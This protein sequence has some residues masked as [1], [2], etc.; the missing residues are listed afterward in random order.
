M[1]NIPRET[2]EDLKTAL[3]AELAA[4]QEELAERGVKSENTWDGSSLSEGEEADPNDAADNIE[5]L[6][7]NVPLVQDLKKR[8]RDIKSAL[9]R[10]D[11][12]SYGTCD[13]CG[14][15][16]T[17]ERLEANPAAN[18]CIRHAE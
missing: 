14:E 5:E 6:V 12:G 2:L 15:E 18:T 17:L 16:I 7:T 11:E 9:T 8:E 13:V 10:M 4:V 3:E 1:Q